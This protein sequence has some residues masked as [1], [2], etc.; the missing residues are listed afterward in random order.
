MHSVIQAVDLKFFLRLGSRQARTVIIF[1]LRVS[2][3][4][5]RHAWKRQVI[6]R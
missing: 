6:E 3:A 4:F 5:K 1:I 2:G